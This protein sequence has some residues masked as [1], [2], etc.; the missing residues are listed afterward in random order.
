M[1]RCLII[2]LTSI[3]ILTVVTNHRH[4]SDTCLNYGA[5]YTCI[6]IIYIVYV[7]ITLTLARFAGDNCI[8]QQVS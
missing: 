5:Y 7:Y 3:R 4:N 6:L 2:S 1:Y 8:M